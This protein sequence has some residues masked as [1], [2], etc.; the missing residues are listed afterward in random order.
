AR[1]KTIHCE[2]GDQDTCSSAIPQAVNW[3]GLLPSAFTTKIASC[4]KP[5][6]ANLRIRLKAM[7]VPSGEKWGS[8]SKPA[9]VTACGLLPSAFIRKMEVVKFGSSGESEEY[10]NVI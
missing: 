3:R 7:R 10:V 5:L 1:L 2:S 6:P 4:W 8:T 9:V